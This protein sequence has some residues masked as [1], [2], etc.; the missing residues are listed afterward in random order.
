MRAFDIKV[1][2]YAPYPV[3]F[4]AIYKAS[5]PATAAA[6]A[7]RDAIKQVLHKRRI[8]NITLK[9]TPL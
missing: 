2:T 8:G 9:I 3:E 7:I 5:S 4:N 6:R 1:T